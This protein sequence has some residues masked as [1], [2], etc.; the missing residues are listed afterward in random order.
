VRLALVLTLCAC[1]DP[2]APR[3]VA[4]PAHKPA[5]A[6]PTGAFHDPDGKRGA[7]PSEAD[8]KKEI[9]ALRDHLDRMYAHRTGKLQRASLDEDAVFAELEQRLLA[10]TTWSRYDTAIY[11]ALTRFHDGHLTYHPPSTAAPARGYTSFH[12]G[13]STVLAGDHLLVSAIEDGSDLAKAGIKPG[14]E[15]LEV[16]G[17]PVADILADEVAHR[18]WSRPESAKIGWVE[19]WTA[20]LYPKGDPPRERK[21]KLRLRSGGDKDLAIVPK[22]APKVKRDAVT[23]TDDRGVAVV[24]IR[25]LT[26]G[27]KRAKQ[28]DE[29]LA[30]ARSSRAMVI[31]LRGDRGGD[32]TQVGERVVAGVAEGKGRLGTY[33]V[34]LAPETVAGRAM[35]KS[36]VAGAD[37]WSGPQELTVDAQPAGKGFHGPVAVIVDAGC[38]STC[39]LVAAALRGDVGAA[40]IGETTGGSSGA[41]IPFELP[42]THGTVNIPTW[43]MIAADGKPVESDGVVPDVQ[44]TPTADSLAMSEDLQMRAAI[45]LVRAR[46]GHA[47]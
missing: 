2:P 19:T 45:D 28:I 20:V 9:A 35:W 26:G 30:K 5:A 17:K 42:V 13:L 31:D 15:V 14:D 12:I 40:V 4:W 23:V 37:G 36:L 6:T 11:E 1:A 16:D 39:E 46:L 25:S 21:L 47:P 22:E 43:D 38:V 34:L 7:L 33:R 41:P 32:I 18:V 10:A 44:S 3:P 27:K 8:R 24:T 29:A